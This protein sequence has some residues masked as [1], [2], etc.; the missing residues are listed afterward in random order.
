MCPLACCA[1]LSLSLAARLTPANFESQLFYTAAWLAISKFQYLVKM[2]LPSVRSSR[3]GFTFFTLLLDISVLCVHVLFFVC[4]VLLL[5]ITFFQL[6]GFYSFP[7][8]F[9]KL[10]LVVSWF[11]ASVGAALLLESVLFHTPVQYNP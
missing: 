7:L 9:I 4:T 8:L 3:C 2:P 6:K 1:S 10:H 5:A 11:T